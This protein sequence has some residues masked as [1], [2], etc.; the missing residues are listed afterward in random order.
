PGFT[1]ASE[2]GGRSH[3]LYQTDRTRLGWMVWPRWFV[4]GFAVDM[5][6]DQP[7][8]HDIVCAD[9]RV[10]KA[11]G[12]DGLPRGRR[13]FTAV[14]CLALLSGRIYALVVSGVARRE[15]PAHDEQGPGP[16]CV[17][18]CRQLL[19]TGF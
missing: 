18:N 19:T 17:R 3:C 1:G 12:P 16:V 14:E 2:S 10:S 13:Q 6:N 4:F 15:F 11:N 7:G 8:S 9:S 5:G